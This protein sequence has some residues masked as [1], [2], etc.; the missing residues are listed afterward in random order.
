MVALVLNCLACS[1]VSEPA[2]QPEQPALCPQWE[3]GEAG[4]LDTGAREV[5]IPASWAVEVPYGDPSC[6]YQHVFEVSVDARQLDG[7]WVR[8][9]WDSSELPTKELC[10]QARV[11]VA[12]W[13]QDARGVWTPWDHFVVS[14]VATQ[15]GC[16]T[17]HQ[18]YIGPDGQRNTDIG[19]PWSWVDTR[20]VSRVRVAAV[21]A[22][23]CTQR[24]LVLGV[25]NNP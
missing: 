10:D 6:P 23:E 12:V 1:G 3:L 2:P 5:D 21:A 9:R 17:D 18:G 19:M 8:H 15:R 14:G 25:S 11:H 4:C 20:E 16:E 7:L 22:T 13:Q 24:S